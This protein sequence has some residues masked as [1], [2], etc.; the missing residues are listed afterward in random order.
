[1]SQ[2]SAQEN[3][4]QDPHVLLS[5]GS[6]F[7]IRLGRAEYV[8]EQRDEL[9][10]K[11]PVLAAR[12]KNTRQK[13]QAAMPE[14]TRLIVDALH[15]ECQLRVGVDRAEDHDARLAATKRYFPHTL[16]LIV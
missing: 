5:D 11:L 16:Q 2:R 8:A 3:E 15:A 6:T 10:Q 4:V 1:M 14:V 12:V 7:D 13:V 9:R